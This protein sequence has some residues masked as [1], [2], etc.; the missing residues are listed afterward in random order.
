[1]LYLIAT[2]AAVI[3]R[4]LAC[5]ESFQQ[6]LQ[7]LFKKQGYKYILGIYKRVNRF[8]EFSEESKNSKPDFFL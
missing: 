2:C 5:K 7:S 3:S 1:M 8:S 4:K 6:I